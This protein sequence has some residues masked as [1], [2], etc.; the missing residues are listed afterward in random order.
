MSDDNLAS[1]DD[2]QC[3]GI[4]TKIMVNCLQSDLRL[5]M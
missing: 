2:G 4:D 1:G 5:T 3:S